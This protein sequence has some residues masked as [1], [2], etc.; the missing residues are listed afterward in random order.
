MVKT[1]TSVLDATL[2]LFAAVLLLCA[3]RLPAQEVTGNI[4]ARV[5]DPSG[6]AGAQP[7]TNTRLST[8]TARENPM[9]S[10]EPEGTLTGP[11][12]GT[13]PIESKP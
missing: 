3:L 6:A 1:G 12:F 4:L 2:K 13:N 10:L 11:V 9:P 5:T 7:E 8:R